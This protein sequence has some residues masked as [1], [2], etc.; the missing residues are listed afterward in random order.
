M[1]WVK[2][3][4]MKTILSHFKGDKVIWL[5]ALSLIVISLL[6]VYSSTG[7][8]AYRYRGG[9]TSFYIFRH[10]SI[11]LFG[12]F[13]MFIAHKVPYGFLYNFYLVI[14]AV[15]GFLLLYTAFAGE[16]EYG[17]KRWAVIGGQ[18]FQTS[19]IAK[20]AVVIYISRI[21]SVSQENRATLIQGFKK[22]MWVVGIACLL[23]V[24]SNL[25]TVIL[26]F[27]VSI[28]LM[29]I[30]NVPVKPLAK[31][32]GIAVVLAIVMIFV[33]PSGSKLERSSTWKHRISSF[34]ND[35]EN[36]QVV[37]AKNAIASSGFVGKG[38]GNSAVKYRLENVATDF[39]FPIIIEELGSILGI[40]VLGLYLALLFRTGIIVRDLSNTFPAFV[41]IGLSLNI[42]FQALVN[43]AV[44]VS[45][46][47]VTGQ[48]LPLVSLGGTSILVTFV[49][50]GIILNINQTAKAKEF[51]DADDSII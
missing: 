28:I 40:F 21:L 6:S 4:N 30:G 9:D 37:L 43:M 24:S 49:S 45:I 41:A 14:V 36:K 26:L 2:Q 8:L 17:A 13:L 25:S 16:A 33:A 10:T 11:L 23:I 5:I 48:P 39:I 38:P 22:I 31:T 7:N 42:V 34:F 1:S 44:G 50:L 18:K 19:D 51:K 3:K 29:F 35:D 47:P 20:F 12:L 15:A 32:I 27:G 46:I